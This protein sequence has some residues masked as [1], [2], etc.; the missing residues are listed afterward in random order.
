MA[1][2]ALRFGVTDRATNMQIIDGMAVS[3]PGGDIG[4]GSD[5]VIP[6]GAAIRQRSARIQPISA[7]EVD[8]VATMMSYDVVL[9]GS[10]PYVL[11][12]PG[13]QSSSEG[14]LGWDNVRP[15]EKVMLLRLAKLNGKKLIVNSAWRSLET[16]S[17]IRSG[18]EGSIPKSG[19]HQ[20]GQAFDI[21]N[22]SYTSLEMFI[23]NARSVGFGGI[24][25]YSWGCH[26]DSRAGDITFR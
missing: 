8:E 17:R 11:Y 7:S 6:G 2:G 16:Q 15:T 5:G 22:S 12:R 19:Y 4:I 25:R 9:N 23:N 3:S 18:S 10:S 14:R 13:P 21:S 24:G 20:S 26:I 1:A